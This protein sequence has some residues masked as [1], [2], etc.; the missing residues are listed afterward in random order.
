MGFQAQILQG[1]HIRET[2]WY[3]TCTASADPQWHGCTLTII[4][5]LSL[6]ME[7]AKS[8][9]LKWLRN[10]FCYW[11]CHCFWHW[12]CHWLYHWQHHWI[13]KDFIFKLTIP[14][15]LS[16]AKPLYVL[17]YMQFSLSL[18]TW[19]PLVI[20]VVYAINIGIALVMWWLWH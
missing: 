7:L 9:N 6:S 17:L 3:S 18:A 2:W 15:G 14:L 20:I 16:F 12:L 11:L 19:L 1:S 13:S 4:L 8:L 10:Y 5:T